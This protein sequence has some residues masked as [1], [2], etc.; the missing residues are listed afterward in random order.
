MGNPNGDFSSNGGEDTMSYQEVSAQIELLEWR[1]HQ[2]SSISE[3][4]NENFPQLRKHLLKQVIT[5]HL[6]KKLMMQASL[7]LRP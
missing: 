2:L 4:L 7:I 1:D 5:E 3:Q 6:V